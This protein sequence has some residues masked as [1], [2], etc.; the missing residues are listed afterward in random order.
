MA[1]P[2]KAKGLQF[3]RRFTKD[4][5]TPYD[6]FEYDYRDSVIKTPMVKKCLR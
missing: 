6:M 1:T 4:G 5:V 3:T 2:S